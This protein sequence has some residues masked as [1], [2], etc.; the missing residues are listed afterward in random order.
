VRLI[1]LLSPVLAG[2]A[3]AGC[4]S[5]ELASV[6]TSAPD[7]A[8]GAPIALS[9]RPILPQKI[10]MSVNQDELSKAVEQFRAARKKAAGP[11]TQAGADLNGDGR[12]E[13][14]VLLSGQD[15]CSPKGCTLVVFQ[16]DGAGF[17]PISET[18]DVKA[19]ISAGSGSNA[20]W[21]DL[22]AA[23]GASRTVRLQYSGNGYPVNASTQPDAS[24]DA[25]QAE[26]LIQPESSQ[27]AT[28]APAVPSAHSQ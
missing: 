7:A 27:T 11:S 10:A 8:P 22:I 17:Q 18:I 20:G 26:V 24:S 1:L 28:A 14:L 19:P 5:P 9:P 12:A 13:A 2:V 25:A 16:P 3:L 15:W 21:R 6:A 4:G 23:T